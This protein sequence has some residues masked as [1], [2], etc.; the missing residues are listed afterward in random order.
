MR[1]YARRQDGQVSAPVSYRSTLRQRPGASQL[2]GAIGAGDVLRVEVDVLRPQEGGLEGDGQGEGEVVAGA[3]Y[4]GSR[5]VNGA[6]AVLQGPH[7]SGCHRPQPL[8]GGIVDQVQLI[9]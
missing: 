3:G 7:G 4:R 8:G 2:P 9:S 5:G 1:D 6:L